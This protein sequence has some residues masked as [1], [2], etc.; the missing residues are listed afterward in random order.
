[1]SLHRLALYNQ[2][3]PVHT[4]VY[5]AH[6]QD[7]LVHNL[8]LDKII[9]P[10]TNNAIRQTGVGPNNTIGC[11]FCLRYDPS[12]TLLATTTGIY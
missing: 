7:I 11:L 12:G 4:H 10:N 6:C 1:M 3:H 8:E 5:Q 2:Y 9:G